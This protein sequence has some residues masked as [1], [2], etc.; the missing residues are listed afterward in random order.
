MTPAPINLLTVKQKRE[1]LVLAT[2]E[3]ARYAFPK[4]LHGRNAPQIRP[5]TGANS[6]PVRGAFTRDLPHNTCIPGSGPSGAILR[7]RVDEALQA[8]NFSEPPQGCCFVDKV[9]RGE[10]L[11]FMHVRFGTRRLF[12]F[13]RPMIR[14]GVGYTG[15]WCLKAYCRY[16]YSGWIALIAVV[17]YL[18][19]WISSPS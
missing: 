7:R 15:A 10:M 17:E 2:F 1:R 19:C 14:V 13:G 3:P 8:P 11:G 18:R 6:T 12:R 9:S 5:T 16:S 4:Q